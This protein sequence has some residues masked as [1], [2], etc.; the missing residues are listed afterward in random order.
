M[1]GPINLN[2]LDTPVVEETQFSGTMKRWLTTSV[3]IINSSF[4]LLNQAFG[5]LIAV[6]GADIGGS[7]AGPI[8]VSNIFGLTSAG[9]VNVN[10]ISSSNPVTVNSVV[11]GTNSFTVTFSAD[12]GASAII[13]YQAYTQQPL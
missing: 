9:F 10:L 12:P 3:D 11:P 8:T 6:N 7:G 2:V 5:F 13:V 1:A 4:A